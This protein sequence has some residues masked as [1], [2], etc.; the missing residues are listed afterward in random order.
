MPV[1]APGW[2]N[3]STVEREDSHSIPSLTAVVTDQACFS[4]EPK[5]VVGKFS[6]YMTLLQAHI[7]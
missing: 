6:S 1:G 5:T 7:V 4:G 3:A 2:P